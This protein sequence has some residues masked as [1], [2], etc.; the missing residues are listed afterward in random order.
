M[1]GK[2]EKIVLSNGRITLEET[3]LLESIK[4][5]GKFGKAV[6]NAFTG[7]GAGPQSSSALAALRNSYFEFLL[8]LFFRT[9]YCNFRNVGLS[10]LRL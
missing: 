6:G 3:Q 8:H 5:R 10:A 7:Q 4:R 9:D 2:L 1:I